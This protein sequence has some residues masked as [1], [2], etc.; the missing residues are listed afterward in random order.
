[1]NIVYFIAFRC[2]FG[3]VFSLGFS[4]ADSLLVRLINVHEE[5]LASASANVKAFALKFLGLHYFKTLQW[6]YLILSFIV[7]G[8]T[9]NLSHG[10]TGIQ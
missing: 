1:M 10:S 2:I 6:I 9:N 4:Q 3:H 7:D 8:I 5:M